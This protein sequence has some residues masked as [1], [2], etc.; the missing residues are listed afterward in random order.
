MCCFILPKFGFSF[1]NHQPS[2][3]AAGFVSRGAWINTYEHE[4]SPLNSF[5]LFIPRW[6]RINSFPWRLTLEELV[7]RSTLPTS[8]IWYPGI[9][10]KTYLCHTV[11]G[12]LMLFAQFL[13]MQLEVRAMT[14]MGEGDNVKSGRGMWCVSATHTLPTLVLFLRWSL[15][16]FW[17]SEEVLNLTSRW[18]AGRGRERK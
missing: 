8:S 5:L 12:W 4:K 7:V 13:T 14:E 16:Y 9:S 10:A 15:I 17:D 1:W 3:L 18:W 2:Q 6:W 11:L